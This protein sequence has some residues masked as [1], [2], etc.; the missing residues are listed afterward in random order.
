MTTISPVGRRRNRGAGFWVLCALTMFVA[1]GA[2]YSSYRH[3]VAFAV[4]YGADADTAMIWPLI[5]DGMLTSCTVVLW[6]MRGRRQRQGRWSAWFTV[7][8]GTLLSLC[9]NI[10]AAPHVSV[11]TVMATGCPPVALLLIELLNHVL[12][13]HS[14]HQGDTV[15]ES[16]PRDEKNDESA[17]PVRLS[18]VSDETRSGAVASAEQR[19]WAHYVTE[20]ASGHVPTGAELDR[21]IGTNNYGRAVLRRWRNEGRIPPVSHRMP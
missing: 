10:T 14:D 4:R 6:M 11:F 3:G 17:Q 15:R 18:V 19:M 2:A 20:R 5:V 12:G 8:V 7:G 16:D 13:Q 1:V 21:A 9:A